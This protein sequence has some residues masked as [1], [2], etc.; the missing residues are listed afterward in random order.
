MNCAPCTHWRNQLQKCILATREC[1]FKAWTTY[2]LHS[3]SCNTSVA[4]Y[5]DIFKTLISWTEKFFATFSSKLIFEMW[6]V[7]NKDAAQQC[8]WGEASHQWWAE[9]HLT[10]NQPNDSQGT[11]VIADSWSYTPVWKQCRESLLG[12]VIGHIW[13]V[14]SLVTFICE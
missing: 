7:W 14:H 12:H 5:P 1:S 2:V 11:S 10:S 13:P 6:H 8:I 3:C 9:M 4:L